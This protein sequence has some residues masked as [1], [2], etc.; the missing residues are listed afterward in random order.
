MSEK[1]LQG[2]RDRSDPSN[3]HSR[4]S[5]TATT[6]SIASPIN[7]SSSPFIFEAEN[8][9]Q[10]VSL[11][12]TSCPGVI[13]GVDMRPNERPQTQPCES[14]ESLWDMEIDEGSP[15]SEFGMHFS[16]DFGEEP[17]PLPYLGDIRSPHSYEPKHHYN[18]DFIRHY[19]D[20]SVK[21]A[22]IS[23]FDSNSSVSTISPTFLG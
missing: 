11:N 18:P 3:F 16:G 15:F 20:I 4:E 23:S 19:E 7:R 22:F 8:L 2:Y 1:V 17:E 14:T 12:D 21:R 5:S 9:F 10:G 6:A 13:S